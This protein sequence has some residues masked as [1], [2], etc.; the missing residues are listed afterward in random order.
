MNKKTRREC[1]EMLALMRE[2]PGRLFSRWELLVDDVGRPKLNWGS[3]YFKI[4]FEQVV[5]RLKKLHELGEVMKV[6][7][8]SDSGVDLWTY[9]GNQHW[10]DKLAR[11]AV[12]EDI[13]IEKL[14][15]DRSDIMWEPHGYADEDYELVINEQALNKFMKLPDLKDEAG[16]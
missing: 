3:G 12:V 6:R 8:G 15:L 5:Y 16:A 7:D 9:A 13:L 10:K 14:N 1:D 11:R 4:S 2:E